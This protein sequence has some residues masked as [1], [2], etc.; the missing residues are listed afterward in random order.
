MNLFYV[1]KQFNFISNIK[2]LEKSWYN[3]PKNKNIIHIIHFTISLK[4]ILWLSY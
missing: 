3:C 1:K 2:R 4:K